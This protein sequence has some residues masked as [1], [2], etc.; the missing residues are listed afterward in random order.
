[1]P[2]T[3]CSLRV[4]VVLGTIDSR[5]LLRAGLREQLE[6]YLHGIVAAQG[7]QLL[8]LGGGETTS[9]CSSA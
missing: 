1:M 7:G 3:F 9:I 6:R 2:G 8:G 5:C 4:H